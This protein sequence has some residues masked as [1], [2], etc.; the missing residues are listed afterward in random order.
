MPELRKD[1]I[2]NRWI[3]IA[4]ERA[5][6]PMASVLSEA[7]DSTACPFCAGNETMTPPEV[8]VLNDEGDP[9]GLSTWTVRVVSNK[10]P[11]LVPEGGEPKIT[12]ENYKP[13]H[14]FGVHEVIIESPNHL[15]NLAL[16]D[17]RQF[18]AILRAYRQRILDLRA[19]PRFR[20]ILI[21][22]NHGIQ[23]GATLEH[24]HSQLIALPFVP[25]KVLEEIDGSRAYYQSN[26]RCAFCDL[27]R[28]EGQ[29][30][31]RVVT[32]NERF[33]AVCPFAPRFPYETWIL[34]KQHAPFFE[35]SSQQDERALAALLRETLIRLNRSLSDPA[36]NY[37]IHS[38]PLNE[39]GTDYYH[40]HLEILPKLLRVGGF[41]WGSGSFINPVTP[42]HSAQSL[43]EALPKNR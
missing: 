6:R 43:R 28:K 29:T 4:P 2:L 13:R 40:W 42:E 31:E 16:L 1:P 8:L 41:E 5:R 23:A 9:A 17:E 11:A 39:K 10:Y 36:F 27:T 38:S 33:I 21:Y 34:P 22:K 15:V 18:E 24:I 35:R 12:D 37:I 19:D 26:G 3:V 20:Y 30:G 7:S 14:G 32:E 25:K